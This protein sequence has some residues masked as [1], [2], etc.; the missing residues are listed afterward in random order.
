MAKSNRA[1]IVFRRPELRLFA[2]GK[3]VKHY[4][5]PK[6]KPNISASIEGIVEQDYVNMDK[7]EREA[8]VAIGRAWVKN[9]EELKEK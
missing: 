6:G 1:T 5:T 3:A 9:E 4:L 2:L 8:Y 7:K